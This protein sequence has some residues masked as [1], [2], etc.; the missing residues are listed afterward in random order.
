MREKAWVSLVR[1]QQL[2]ASLQSH[3]W[4]EGAC[5]DGTRGLKV[6]SGTCDQLGRA[7]TD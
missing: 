5:C 6:T 1:L 2:G 4:R 7:A 3:G